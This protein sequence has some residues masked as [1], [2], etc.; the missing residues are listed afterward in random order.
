VGKPPT[1]PKV[2]LVYRHGVVVATLSIIGE[3]QKLNKTEKK[4]TSFGDDEVKAKMGIWW[5][6]FLDRR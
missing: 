6:R 4:K 2:F 3:T 5:F 1:I